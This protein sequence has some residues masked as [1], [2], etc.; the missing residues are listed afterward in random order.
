[1]ALRRDAGAAAEESLAGRESLSDFRDAFHTHKD[2]VY[3]CAYRMTGLCV[4]RFRGLR[5]NATKGLSHR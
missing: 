4:T 2:I 3:R 1:M 5:K